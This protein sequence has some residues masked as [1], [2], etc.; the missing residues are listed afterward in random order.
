[1][2]D[3]E[4]SP[5]DTTYPTRALIR[6]LIRRSTPFPLAVFEQFEHCQESNPRPLDHKSDAL[7]TTLRSHIY[8]YISYILDNKTIH[9]KCI[10]KWHLIWHFIMLFC[11]RTNRRVSWRPSQK[12]VSYSPAYCFCYVYC[13]ED[14]V[15]CRRGIKP[16]KGKGIAS[17]QF[18]WFDLSVKVKHSLCVCIYCKSFS[19]DRNVGSFSE[20]IYMERR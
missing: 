11:L 7:T 4:W 20:S 5:P 1:M 6:L 3:R 12:G 2:V 14:V 9:V 8:I 17:L 19:Y 13:V 18:I 10:I 16:A 15:L